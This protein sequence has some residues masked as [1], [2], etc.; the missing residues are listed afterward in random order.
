LALTRGA[1]YGFVEAAQV[2][3]RRRVQRVL[4]GTDDSHISA[5]VTRTR[6]EV[7]VA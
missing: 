5:Y 2:F 4:G 7:L 6:V 3:V 1:V